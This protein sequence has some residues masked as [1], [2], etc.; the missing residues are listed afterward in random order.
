MGCSGVG[1]GGG[2]KKGYLSFVLHDF[3]GEGGQSAIKLLSHN[4]LE[5]ATLL[6]LF[7]E[8]PH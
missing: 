4:G 3:R 5:G 2:G 6:V 8:Q 7:P 1:G